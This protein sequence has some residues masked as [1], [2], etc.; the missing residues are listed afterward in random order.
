M[1]W[2]VFAAAGAQTPALKLLPDEASR[3]L[4]KRAS[5][6]PKK[7]KDSAAMTSINHDEA[8]SLL[9]ETGSGPLMR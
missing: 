6:G 4:F 2:L 3:V 1:Y 8:V 7:T 9:S 5:E